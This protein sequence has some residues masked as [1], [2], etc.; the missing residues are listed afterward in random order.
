MVREAYDIIL[1]AKKYV[2]GSKMMS[3]AQQGK[4]C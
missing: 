3:V 1:C 2:M 4:E